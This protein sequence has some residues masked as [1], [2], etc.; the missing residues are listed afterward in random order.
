MISLFTGLPGHGKTLYVVSKLLEMRAQDDARPLYVHGIRG[1]TVDHVDLPDGRDW[2]SCPDGSLIV[3]DEAQSAFPT[4][5]SGTPPAHVAELAKHRHRGLDLWLISQH[6]GNIDSFIRERLI[7]EHVHVMRIFGSESAMVYRWTEC[8]S[9]PRSMSARS[10]AL[11]SPWKYPKG[12]YAAYSSAV[13]HTA[14]SRLPWTKLALIGLGLA[15]PV[16]FYLAFQALPGRGDD[17]SPPAQGTAAQ[18]TTQQ[19]AAVPLTPEQWLARWTPRVVYRPESAPAYDGVLSDVKPP[20]I[21]CMDVELKGCR[22]YTE[23]ATP[24]TGVPEATCR[25]LAR[26]GSYWHDP[27]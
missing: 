6:P 4:R 16:V 11:A 21:A 19:A 24:W 3:I 10:A 25:R 17:A 13:M 26:D 15:A 9:D 5:G 7:E 22:C 27:G 1:L 23:Q 14:K 8:Q 2:A 18:P 20:R 12:S